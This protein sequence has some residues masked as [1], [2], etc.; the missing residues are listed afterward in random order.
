M[1]T[2]RELASICVTARIC[3]AHWLLGKPGEHC[4]CRHCR[5]MS[6]V[7]REEIAREEDAELLAAEAQGYLVCDS[8]LW[9]GG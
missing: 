9:A 3:V 8:E 1:K 2:V 4:E 7:L 6:A 5:A